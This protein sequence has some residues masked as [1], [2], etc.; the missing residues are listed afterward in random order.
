VGQSDLA[1]KYPERAMELSARWHELAETTDKRN[2]KQ[3]R[4]VK[5]KPS[6]HSQGS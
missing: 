6:V 1:D 3:R 5:D 2:E 4:P